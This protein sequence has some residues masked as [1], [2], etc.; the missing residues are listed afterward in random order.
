MGS[1]MNKVKILLLRRILNIRPQSK[2]IDTHQHLSKH[3]FFSIK[4]LK[5]THGKSK[6]VSRN[7]GLREA[8]G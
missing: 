3:S 2:C 4:W 5:V 6:Y 7:E 8:T 1:A